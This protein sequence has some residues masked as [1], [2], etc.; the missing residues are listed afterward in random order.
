MNPR[1][2]APA[3][4]DPVPEPHTGLIGRFRNYFLTGLVVTGPVAITKKQK[5]KNDTK[6]KKKQ[7]KTTNKKMAYTFPLARNFR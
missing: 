1:D 4:L 6:K 7:R 3:P 5:K 2:D